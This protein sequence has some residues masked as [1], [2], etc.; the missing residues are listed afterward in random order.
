M[1]EQAVSRRRLAGDGPLAQGFRGKVDLAYIDPPFCSNVNYGTFI[2]P[3]GRPAY[4]LLFTFTETRFGDIWTRDEYPQFMY[5]RLIL[6]RELLSDRGSLFLH[7]DRCSQH[8]LRCLLDEV[9][10]ASVEEEGSPGLVNEIVWHHPHE[11]VD[12]NDRFVPSHDTVFWYSKTGKY[13]FNATNV[14]EPDPKG[15]EAKVPP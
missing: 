10:G 4:P 3:K 2:H 15:A 7:C 8:L 5:E 6:I 12:R 1:D 14:T 13:H 9:F 11:P